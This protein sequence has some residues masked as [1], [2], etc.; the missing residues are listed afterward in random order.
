MV[1]EKA[2]AYQAFQQGLARVRK[3]NKEI[4]LLLEKIKAEYLEEYK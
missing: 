1:K 2:E 4:D 3:I